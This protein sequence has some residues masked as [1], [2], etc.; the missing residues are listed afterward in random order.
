MD[1]NNSDFYY[2]LP[3][4]VRFYFIDLGGFIKEERHSLTLRCFL[5]N[6]LKVTKRQ[7]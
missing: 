7:N 1:R 6:C 3:A 4:K 2:L 5:G